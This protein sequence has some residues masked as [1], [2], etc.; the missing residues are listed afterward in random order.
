M[1]ATW[2]MTGSGRGPAARSRPAPAA[3]MASSDEAASTAAQALSA[4]GPKMSPAGTT[5][6]FR[7]EIFPAE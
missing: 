2:S 3:I 6:S 4:A 7:V 1:A 5:R